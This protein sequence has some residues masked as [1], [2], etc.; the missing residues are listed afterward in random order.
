MSEISGVDSS[1]QTAALVQNMNQQQVQAQLVM[2]MLKKMQEMQIQA[3][4][5]L[6]MALN[7]D[8]KV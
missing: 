6:G 4:Q 2:E 5:S 8:V 3:M 1:V 7:I